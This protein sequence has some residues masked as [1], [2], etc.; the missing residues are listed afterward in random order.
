MASEISAV[1]G[2]A[3]PEVEDLSEDLGCSV[4]LR[5]AV[6]CRQLKK[7]TWNQTNAQRMPLNQ[8]F[9]W[10]LTFFTSLGIPL[11]CVYSAH[12]P[13]TLGIPRSSQKS[14]SLHR[15]SLA[16]SPQTLFLSI[17]SC[18]SEWYRTFWVVCYNSPTW[19]HSPFRTVTPAATIILVTSRRE[20][21]EIY[22][23][24]ILYN[25]TLFTILHILYKHEE[26][27]MPYPKPRERPWQSSW[28]L[29]DYFPTKQKRWFSVRQPANDPHNLGFF[30]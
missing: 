12:R 10:S 13:L 2:F 21:V 18:T 8:P 7:S 24:N 20:V 25:I 9:H 11:Q 1:M 3:K 30:T 23:E 17:I 26:N 14:P 28:S 6:T 29:E 16:S 27:Q 4:S 22:P 19:N 5:N 15:K